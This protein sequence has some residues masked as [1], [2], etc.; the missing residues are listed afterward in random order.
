MLHQ[1]MQKVNYKGIRI[2]LYFTPL[3]E[4]RVDVQHNIYL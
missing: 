2:L 1:A 4:H 3:K